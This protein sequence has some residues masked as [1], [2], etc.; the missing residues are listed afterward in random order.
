MYTNFHNFLCQ[1][2]RRLLSILA[3]QQPK[4]Q[5][6]K[7][8]DVD[9]RIFD[10]FFWYYNLQTTLTK[11]GSEK[12][13]RSTHACTPSFTTFSPNIHVSCCLFSHNYPKQTTK[14]TICYAPASRLNVCYLWHQFTNEL[15]KKAKHKKKCGAHTHA[16][17]LFA[18]LLLIFTMVVVYSRTTVQKKKTTKKCVVSRTLLF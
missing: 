16:H 6:N 4:K 17:Q 5:K 14:Q 11:E 1:Y 8:C 2:S 18:H 7:I 12:K 10:L 9:S 15:N 13:M 3:P